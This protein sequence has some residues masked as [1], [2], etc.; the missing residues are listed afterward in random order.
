MEEWYLLTI[1]HQRNGISE[2]SARFIISVFFIGLSVFYAREVVSKMETIVNWNRLEIQREERSDW[3]T[4]LKRE[5]ARGKEGILK[6]D[7]PKEVRETGREA[8]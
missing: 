4:I 3:N 1:V 5:S 8:V 6:T 7:W 2:S